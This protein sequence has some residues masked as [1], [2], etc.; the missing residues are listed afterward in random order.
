M[1]QTDEITVKS[2]VTYDVLATILLKKGFLLKEE[3]TLEDSY[4]VPWNYNEENFSFNEFIKETTIIRIIDHK[5]VFLLKKK[6]NF[7]ENGLIVSQ[8][9]ARHSFPSLDIAKS[10]LK[11]NKYIFFAH[12]ID[13]CSI[14]SSKSISLIVQQV[15]DN[16]FIEVECKSLDGINKFT[17]IDSLIKS[18][19]KLDLPIDETNYY[20][21]KLKTIL[22]R[23]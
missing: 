14:F 7:D 5:E 2:L 3:F 10:F 20:V 13:N 12:M 17:S 6:K 16:V 11:N 23:G 8:N 15:K 9:E 1:K 18:F 4:Y 21:S 19:R 22:E